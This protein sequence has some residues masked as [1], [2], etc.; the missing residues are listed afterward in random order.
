MPR[1]QTSRKAP[2]QAIAR[3]AALSVQHRTPSLARDRFLRL[4]EVRARIAGISRSTL[5]RMIAEG[6]FPAPYD[7]SSEPGE[8]RRQGRTIAGWLESEVVAWIESRTAVRQASAR[9]A[10]TSEC[11]AA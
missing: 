4:P 11:E 6:R 1:Q 2:A 5:Y 10:V 8:P 9:A 7:L 3:N